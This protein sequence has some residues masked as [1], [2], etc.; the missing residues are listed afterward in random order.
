MVY[1][2]VSS[3][4]ILSPPSLSESE[5]KLKLSLSPV[6]LLHGLLLAYCTRFLLLA[7]LLWLTPATTFLSTF[8][9]I[10]FLMSSV[11][12]VRVLT[13]QPHHQCLVIMLVTHLARAASENFGMVVS[14]SLLLCD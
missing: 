7:A 14:E 6:K 4:I 2:A 9:D 11:S 13:D 10:F 1:L 8:V 5:S 3:F 12:V